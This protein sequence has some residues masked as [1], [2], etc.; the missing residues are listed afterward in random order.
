MSTG[1][2]VLSIKLGGSIG[3]NITSGTLL[4]D[5]QWHT[6]SLNRTGL[7]I[8]LRVDSLAS[9]SFTLAGP[10]LTLEYSSSG[11]FVG[12]QPG[13]GD[14]VADG[15]HGCLEDLRLNHNSLPLSESNDFASVTFIGG[16]ATSGCSVGPCFP[17]PC[18]PGNCSESSNGTS[19]LCMCPD[20]RNQTMECETGVT[21]TPVG[22]IAIAVAVGV[23]AL[24]LLVAMTTGLL[25]MIWRVRKSKRYNLHEP[26]T[27]KDYEVHANVYS[28]HEEGGGEADTN[29]DDGPAAEVSIHDLSSGGVSP[30][31]SVTT[32]EKSRDEASPS[33]PYPRA[34]TPDID[35][36]I[37]DR[38][39]LANKDIMDLDSIREYC[40]EG[41]GSPSGSLSSICPSIDEEPYS[42]ARLRRA[43]QEFQRVA[44]L[45]EPVLADLD[46][47]SS[48]KHKH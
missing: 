41:T 9:I 2:L 25:V 8:S 22:P 18:T 32:M 4:N 23:F 45:L 36:F 42:I 40:D 12:G 33:P 7:S 11:I 21:A 5:M 6:V 14:T 28:Y 30:V 17:N 3:T 27:A 39:N 13:P 47:E 26:R 1:Q 31:S 38:V 34:T 20:G 37:E 43:G 48:S 10:S 16:S 46:Y 24:L 15:Y 44:D 35:C 29:V 19:F